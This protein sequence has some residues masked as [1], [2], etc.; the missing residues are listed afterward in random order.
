MEEELHVEIIRSR[1]KTYSISVDQDGRVTMRAPLRAPKSEIQRLLTEREDWIRWH[2]EKMKRNREKLEESDIPSLT[3]A[4]L[5]RLTEEARAYLPGRVAYY[6]SVMGIS[7]GRITIRHQKSRWGSCSSAG[8][9]NFNCLLMLAPAEVIDYVV[10][11]ELCHRRYMNHSRE[12]WD[13]VG[14]Y[15]PDY[16]EKEKWLKDHGRE[17]MYTMR[18]V[19]D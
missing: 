16:K 4:G 12:F 10:V 5:N 7:Y 15:M 9:L 19:Q 3:E 17:L 14:K 6:A 8:N 11:H 13:E 2:V 18:S 1:R